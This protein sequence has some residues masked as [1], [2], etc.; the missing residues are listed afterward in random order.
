MFERKAFDTR[1]PIRRYR[2]LYDENTSD[3]VSAVAAAKFVKSEESRDASGRS[4]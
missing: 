2:L 3:A 1:Y 4:G